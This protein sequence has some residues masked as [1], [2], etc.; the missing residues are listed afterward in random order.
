MENT[1][2]H[3]FEDHHAMV[4]QTISPT[5]K[6]SSSDSLRKLDLLSPSDVDR[7]C[8]E[9]HRSRAFV[10]GFISHNSVSVLVGDSGLGKS[11]LGY[12]LGLCVAAGIPF[13]DM[14]TEPGLVVY[15][16]YENGLIGSRDLRDSLVRFL[17]FSAAPE[18][19]KVWTPDA[20]PR[21]LVVEEV[22]RDAKPALLVV[23]SL[24]S[25]DS[26]FESTE[27]AGTRMS[28]LRSLAA[29]YGVAI[30]AIH[31]VR[32]PGE[33][34]GPSLDHEDTVLMQWLNQASG[35]RSIINQSDTR[36]AADLPSSKQRGEMVLCWHRRIYGAGG[37]LYL[38]RVSDEAGDPIG[39]QRLRGARLLGN[40]DQ[41][42][43]F[44]RLSTA[45]S[46]KDAKQ[47]YERS[48]D[49]TRKWLLKSVSVGIVEQVGRGEYRKVETRDSARAPGN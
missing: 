35:H 4:A 38:E 14:R 45:F 5:A 28:G 7:L 36:I 48:D 9:E 34:A 46:F 19:F 42:A 23:D 47:A 37:P 12:Q 39:Y 24:R 43:A 29:K 33:E 32:K 17:G 30:F 11:P 20:S 15:A 22:C 26:S 3:R 25:H 41:E 2:L 1:E 13:L 40:A 21:S 44:G 18:N 8:A 10:E 6:H 16:D 31:H 49:P 27:H